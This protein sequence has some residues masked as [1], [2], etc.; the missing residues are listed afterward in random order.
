[1]RGREII[2]AWEGTYSS[3]GVYAD[4]GGDPFQATTP[5]FSDVA[6]QGGL[7]LKSEIL[8]K[9]KGRLSLGGGVATN[10]TDLFR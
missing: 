4:E 8:L 10:R 6:K 1:M 2:Q 7:L 3:E 5:L 9:N